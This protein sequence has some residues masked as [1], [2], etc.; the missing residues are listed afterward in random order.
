VNSLYGQGKDADAK[1]IEERWL[2][3]VLWKQKRTSANEMEPV[4]V[5]SDDVVIT[6][7]THVDDPVEYVNL[8]QDEAD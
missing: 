7:V 2:L 1:E 8:T 6:A 3:P 4:S 5:D